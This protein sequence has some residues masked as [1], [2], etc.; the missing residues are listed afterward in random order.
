MSAIGRTFSCIASSLQANG[1]ECISGATTDS[2]ADRPNQP[3]PPDNT[4]RL[5]ISDS[6]VCTETDCLVS[7]ARV[8]LPV[9]ACYNIHQIFLLCMRVNT[10]KRYPCIIALPAETHMRYRVLELCFPRLRHVTVRLKLDH[11]R[12]RCDDGVVWLG[13]HQCTCFVK[14][15]KKNIQGLDLDVDPESMSISKHQTQNEPG[16]SMTP[17]VVVVETELTLIIIALVCSQC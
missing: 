6:M 16:F 8:H 15:R 2:R 17:H 13:V 3:Q 1:Y 12:M 10:C 4:Y 5:L 7:A 9:I 11:E 14:A